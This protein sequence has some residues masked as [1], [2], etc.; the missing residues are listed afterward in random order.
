M[1]ELKAGLSPFVT[2]EL[3]AKLGLNWEEDV[4]SR[5]RGIYRSRDG[6]INWDTNAVLKAMVDNWQ[7]VFRNVL[8]HV[9]R[10]YVGE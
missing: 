9:E 8:G 2:R 7:S 5:S 4:T 10:S 6:T 3:R 1:E